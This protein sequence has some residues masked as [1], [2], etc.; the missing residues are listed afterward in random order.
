[1]KEISFIIYC[2]WLMTFYLLF[3]SFIFNYFVFHN[4]FYVCSTDKL[5]TGMWSL[6]MYF[7]ELPRCISLHIVYWRNTHRYVNLGF[8]VWLTTTGCI[9]LDRVLWWTFIGCIGLEEIHIVISNFPLQPPY[10]LYVYFSGNKSVMCTVIV[11][12]IILLLSNEK[13]MCW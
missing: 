1:M 10:H 13:S 5:F 11:V 6:N 7:G 2:K 9:N 12:Y 4:L 8:F 3:L